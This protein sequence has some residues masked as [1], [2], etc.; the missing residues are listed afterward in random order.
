[1][2]SQIGQLQISQDWKRT[3]VEAGIV[4]FFLKKNV[5]MMFNANYV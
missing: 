1:M 5:L 3:L 4:R 2:K